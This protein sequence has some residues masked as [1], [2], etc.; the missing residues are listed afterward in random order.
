MP[1]VETDPHWSRTV[2]LIQPTVGDTAATDRTGRHR[3]VLNEGA[4]VAADGL[5]PGHAGIALDGYGDYVSVAP[6]ADWHLGGEPFTLEWV[7]R[8]DTFVRVRCLMSLWTF[9]TAPR[10]GFSIRVRA[11]RLEFAT[12]SG[13]THGEIGE[14]PLDRG[15]GPLH[16]AVTGDGRGGC[17]L[18]V[19]GH[20][21]AE[22]RLPGPLNPSPAPLVVGLEGETEFYL[23][24]T[25]DAVRITRGV[26]RTIGPLA[27]PF[28]VG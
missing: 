26:A 10:C 22:G 20:P 7:G 21:F 3:P 19:D 12:V 1:V 18:F 2:L 14:L 5:W 27:G 4:R 8:V 6:H 16:V 9:A 13:N 24:G 11:G 23:Q 25:V 17:R 28:P 15:P